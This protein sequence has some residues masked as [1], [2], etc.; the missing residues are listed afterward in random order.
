MRTYPRN[1]TS[2]G[3]TGYRKGDPKS[4]GGGSKGGGGKK[5]RPVSGWEKGDVARDIDDANSSHKL[6]AKPGKRKKLLS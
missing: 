6:K 2:E 3:K 1:S 5:G 4:G